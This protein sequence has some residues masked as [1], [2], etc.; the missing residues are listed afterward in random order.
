MSENVFECSCLCNNIRLKVHLVNLNMGVCH[1]SMCRKNTSGTGFSFFYSLTEPVFIS[2]DR[3][4]IYNSTGVAD[5]AFCSN[6]GTTIY[7]HKVSQKGYCIASGIIENLD[8][9]E[10]LFNREWYHSDKP[11]YYSYNNDTQKQ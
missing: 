9:A 10:V 3:L 8:E 5:R 4:S 6:C 1:C 7:Y 11:Q 2:K